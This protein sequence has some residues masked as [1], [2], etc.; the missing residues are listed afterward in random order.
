M[1]FDSMS[2]LEYVQMDI[3][4]NNHRLEQFDRDQDI[5]VDRNSLDE[6]SNEYENKSEVDEHDN[7]SNVSLTSRSISVDR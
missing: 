2:M 6:L 4:L 1:N 7:V 5:A 3:E